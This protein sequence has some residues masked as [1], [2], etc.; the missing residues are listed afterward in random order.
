MKFNSLHNFGV[1]YITRKPCIIKIGSV[2]KR[3]KHVYKQ[4]YLTP[5]LSIQ[6][7]VR[8]KNSNYK[9]YCNKRNNIT[10]SANYKYRTAATLCRLET[11]F[12]TGI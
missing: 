4:P 10:R 3:I 11:L 12:V 2:T 6:C 1:G 5:N 9:T 7:K 8:V